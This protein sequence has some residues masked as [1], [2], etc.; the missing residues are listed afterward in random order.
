MELKSMDKNNILITGDVY[1]NAQIMEIF[2]VS[3]SGGIRFS[4]QHE[5]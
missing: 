4:I 5:V 1:S 3:N 2:R